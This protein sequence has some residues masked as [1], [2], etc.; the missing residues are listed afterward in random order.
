MIYPLPLFGLR[1]FLNIWR[2]HELP[3]L[4]KSY[5]HLTWHDSGAAALAS[6]CEQIFNR[7]RKVID[8]WLPAY[9]C[10]QSL[11]YL[12]R[13]PLRL[14]FYTLTN[15]LLPDYEMI[16][17]SP[18]L[19][20]DI[21]I[22]VH[23]FGKVGSQLLSREFADQHGA[24]FVE[25]CAH[26][27][28]PLVNQDWYGDY[29]IFAPHKHFAIPNVGIVVGRLDL[30]ENNSKRKILKTTLWILKQFVNKFRPRRKK[31]VW[32]I[33]Y[34]ALSDKYVAYMPSPIIKKLSK[35]N[36]A[37]YKDAHNA[38]RE[39]A[40]YLLESLMKYKGWSEFVPLHCVDTPFILGMLCDS[41]ELAKKRF[42]LLNSSV[43]LVMQWPDLIEEIKLNMSN[44]FQCEDWVGRVLFFFV[45]Q[46]L[47]IKR[48][49]VEIETSMSQNGV[50]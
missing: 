28:S 37:Y 10:S 48:L 12:R 24:V 40:K 38:R 39:N 3:I 34:S 6:I 32:K 43:Q 18:S 29:L 19:N 47:N 42:G 26:I 41:Q 46:E 21:F 14:H 20:V 13:L 50:N 2:L 11:R 36:L 44:Q 23:Y 15:E 17:K 45:H 7:R 4:P 25:D 30:E 9:F 5:D 1:D 16:L 33:D 22:H 27:I 31:L 8:V 49:V 35:L